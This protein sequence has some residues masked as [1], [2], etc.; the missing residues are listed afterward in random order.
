MLI[1]FCD[2]YYYYFFFF[3]AK[4]LLAFTVKQSLVL[5]R[6]DFPVE[7]KVLASSDTLSEPWL[8]SPCLHLR[9]GSQF[10]A[11]RAHAKKVTIK[12]CR[13]QSLCRQ[14][15]HRGLCSHSCSR[16]CISTGGS[17]MGFAFTAA[18]DL[19]ICDGCSVGFA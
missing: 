3:S 6:S 19:H 8:L 4:R 15:C 7:S 14:H 11:I 9:T 5:E 13:D 10:A 12:T 2:V 16:F 18:Q 17:V 1:G